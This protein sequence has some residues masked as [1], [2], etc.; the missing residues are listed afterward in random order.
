[1]ISIS[2]RLDPLLPKRHPS[3]SLS[4]TVPAREVNVELWAKETR[5]R[6]TAELALEY[7][8]NEVLLADLRFPPASRP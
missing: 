2:G 5:D 3:N 6:A 1:M 4:L 7:E 8:L